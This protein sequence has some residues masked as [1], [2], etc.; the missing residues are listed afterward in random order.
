M[1]NRLLVRTNGLSSRTTSI[2]SSSFFLSCC[3]KRRQPARQSGPA[4]DNPLFQRVKDVSRSGSAPAGGPA[5]GGVSRSRNARRLVATPAV[6]RWL[7][8]TV[9]L[10]LFPAVSTHAQPS[11][12]N[13]MTAYRTLSQWI[14]AWNV[15]AQ[16]QSIDP[17]GT[18]AA[19]VT[20]RLDGRIMGRASAVSDHGDALWQAAKDAWQKAAQAL[21]VPRDALRQE[22]LLALAPAIAI[23]LEL[24][25]ALTPI[26][27][28]TFT[29]AALSVSAGR[30]GVAAR[31]GDRTAAV[32][33]GF[34]LSTNMT[35]GSA[36]LAALGALDLTP[37]TLA[38]LRKSSGL[39]LY[40]FDVQ[41][42]AQ[43]Q[44]GRPPLFLT[45][46]GRLVHTSDLTPA[47]LRTFGDQLAANLVRRKW[48]GQAPLGLLG[49]YRPWS[50]Q[51]E[52][53]NAAKPLDQ[54][55]AAFALARWA[56]LKQPDDPR[57]ADLI[58]TSRWIL[59]Q[60]ADV[61]PEET[62]LQGDIPASSM[63]TLANQT[64]FSLTH[65]P[66]PTSTDPTKPTADADGAA[67]APPGA[68]SSGVQRREK[69]KLPPAVRALR[70][71]AVAM[72]ARG[73]RNSQLAMVA[74]SSV[75]E[76]FKETPP[77][78]L[79]SQMPWIGWAELTLLGPD[80]RIPSAIALR[81]FRQLVE[82][83]QLN[84]VDVAASGDEDL[85]GG[86]VFTA[87]AT[88]LP[89]WNT[90]RPLIFLATMLGD[91]RLTSPAER[92]AHLAS[93]LNGLRFVQQL[94]ISDAQAH[95]LPNHDQAVGGVRMA[96]WDQ[97]QP[98]ESTAMA[99][100]LVAETLDSVDAIATPD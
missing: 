82:E 13:T 49:T 63:Q 94:T 12:A 39:I 73:Q 91:E 72:T 18:T 71:L 37:D 78:M 40:R 45:R 51:F 75:R 28:A 70:A 22:R 3:K 61:A 10:A 93:I 7:W 4:T 27:A 76:L 34:M 24:A 89:T 25:G 56:Q 60:L 35:P 100:L 48:P 14:G 99:L 33:P 38:S 59:D 47:S 54:A 43:P 95:M 69:V 92:P 21:P 1:R 52:K 67:T 86:V 85:A 16:A 20:L 44:A 19:S 57:R 42:L 46:G 31:I 77:A 79:A 53:P 23:D 8:A 87:S 80:D 74:R 58:A 64:L 9:A 84:A 55:L 2:F 17:P 36:M 29:D 11:A 90:I 30:Q 88:P 83:H 50:D 81:Q 15:P 6:S 62:S 5:G 68:S 98:I 65:P 41:R 66:A 97:R 96:L 26:D 32:F